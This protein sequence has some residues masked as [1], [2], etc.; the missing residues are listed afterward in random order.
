MNTQAPSLKLIKQNMNF[1]YAASSVYIIECYT[2]IRRRR[3]FISIDYA[4][5]SSIAGL[6]RVKCRIAFVVRVRQINAMI[7]YMVFYY[8][9]IF[10]DIAN[11][12]RPHSSVNRTTY[13]T[14]ICRTR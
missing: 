14:Y 7:Y 13:T 3:E 9:G 10:F 5:D 1:V 4:R 8:L 6:L 12:N 2:C 11:S